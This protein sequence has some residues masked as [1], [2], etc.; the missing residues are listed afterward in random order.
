LAQA[1]VGGYASP[2]FSQNAEHGVGA[3][4]A[5]VEPGRFIGGEAGAMEWVDHCNEEPGDDRAD[6][7]TADL[8]QELKQFFMP[9]GL[10]DTEE[11]SNGEWDVA[12]DD[13]LFL[14]EELG[15]ASGVTDGA[16]FDF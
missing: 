4:T 12:F 14:P 1:T 3:V 9:A 2:C 16:L 7:G 13:G 6:A 15:S 8:S 5:C 11:G 10:M